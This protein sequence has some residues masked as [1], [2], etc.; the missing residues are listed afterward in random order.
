MAALLD[1]MAVTIAALAC[2][3]IYYAVALDSTPPVWSHLGWGGTVALT[4]VVVAALRGD[5]GLDAYRHASRRPMDLWVNWTIA[6]AIVV[7]E[8]FLLKASVE[9]SRGATILLYGFGFL[10]LIG[11]REIGM[12]SLGCLE[13]RGR[14]RAR[15]VL[16]VAS[17]PATASEAVTRLS[18][19]AAPVVIRDVAVNEMSGPLSELVATARQ[20][21][22]DEIALVFRSDEADEIDR[23]AD[24][25]AV[26][27]AGMKLLPESG[28]LGA[29]RAG[30]MY[31]A[32]GIPLMRPPLATSERILK[33]AL[34]LTGASIL[35]VALAPILVSIALAIR[36]Q[37]P[38]PALFRQ[39]RHG[40]NQKPFR[41]FKFRTMSV[42]EDGND[43]TQARTG[44]PRITRIGHVLRR[45]NLDELPQLFNVLSG[46]MSLVGPR[47]HPVALDES[48][49]SRIVH[50]ARRNA[51]KPG[52]TGWAQVHG[53][54]GETDTIEKMSA[55][56]EY[57][58]AYI[59]NWSIGLD[60]QILLMTVFSRMAYRNAG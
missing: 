24:A 18:D 27:P 8:M 54:R 43:V 39:T 55:R 11:S 4:L 20:F 41:I 37:S 35:I 22:P 5:Y 52:I 47:P 14:V 33:R 32:R 42:M 38:G 50:Y 57:D 23:I 2:G 59:E 58:L 44:D 19:T 9:V 30:S 31:G 53:L 3:A 28:R 12:R 1:F 26:I 29:L 34:D 36:I 15:R 48:F 6:M 40:F 60:F 46:E 56:V 16:I 13:R 49:D 51:I 45:T 10:T 7:I 17:N 25:L 21:E